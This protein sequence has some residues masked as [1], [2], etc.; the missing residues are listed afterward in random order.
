M[1]FEQFINIYLHRQNDKLTQAIYESS[2]YSGQL[3]QNTKTFRI[4]FCVLKAIILFNSTAISKVFN[5]NGNFVKGLI[6]GIIGRT[7]DTGN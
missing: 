1:L 7:D 5:M 2:V 6:S 3:K 4:L